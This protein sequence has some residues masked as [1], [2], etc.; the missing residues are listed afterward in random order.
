M[1]RKTFYLISFLFSLIG[2]RQVTNIDLSG[3]WAFKADPNDKGITEKWY[4]SILEDAIQLPGSMATNGKGDDITVNTP[5]TGQIVDSSW[6]KEAKY[7][8]YRQPGNIKIPFWLQPNKHYVGAAWYQK[9]VDIPASWKGKFIQLYL[10]RCHWE[11]AFGSTTTMLA[12]KMDWEH[13]IFIT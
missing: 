6:F 7:E 3:E 11:I 12:H 8:K 2:C 10:E 13:P 1:S 4:S 9:K 5:W